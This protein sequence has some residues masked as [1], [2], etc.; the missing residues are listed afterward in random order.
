ME[1]EINGCDVFIENIE[2]IRA[3][4]KKFK[5]NIKALKREIEY[6]EKQLQKI[7]NYFEQLRIIEKIFEIGF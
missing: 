5:S 7:E 1:I 3:F 2:D 4:K 6:N